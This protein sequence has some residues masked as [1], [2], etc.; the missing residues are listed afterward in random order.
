MG[1]I[2]VGFASSWLAFSGLESISQIAPALREP[3]ERTALRAMMLVVAGILITSPLM[4]AFE[5]ALLNVPGSTPSSSCS[6]WAR[7]SGRGR[8][9]WPSC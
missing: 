1:P 6:S 8:W 4:T 2:L 5:T 7:R 9:S 3:R